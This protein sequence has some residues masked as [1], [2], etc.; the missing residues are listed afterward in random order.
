MFGGKRIT[1]PT[2]PRSIRLSSAADA[3]VP[4]IRTTSFWPISSAAVG[5]AVADGDGAA[6]AVGSTLG[7]RDGPAVAV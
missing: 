5:A 2:S 3:V 6:D 7:R 4:L 1:P